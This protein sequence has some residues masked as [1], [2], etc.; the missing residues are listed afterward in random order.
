[1]AFTETNPTT[2]EGREAQ[3]LAKKS[4]QEEGVL[5]LPVGN[6]LARLKAA[7]VELSESHAEGQDWVS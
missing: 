5:I 6:R 2:S 4:N 7:I 3:V 1:M